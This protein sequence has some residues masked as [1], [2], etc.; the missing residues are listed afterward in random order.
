MVISKREGEEKC[1]KQLSPWEGVG[2]APEKKKGA[3]RGKTGKQEKSVYQ[4]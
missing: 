3:G 1:S 2:V 4:R